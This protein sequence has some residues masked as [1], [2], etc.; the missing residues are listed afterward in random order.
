MP[1][2]AGLK[3]NTLSL[4]KLTGKRHKSFPVSSSCHLDKDELEVAQVAAKCHS[5]SLMRV[6]GWEGKG[7]EVSVGVALLGLI[8]I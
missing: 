2:Y 6:C 1:R 3:R 7:K 5:G 8:L 4:K